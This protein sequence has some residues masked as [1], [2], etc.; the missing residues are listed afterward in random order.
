[1]RLS[2][3]VGVFLLLAGGTLGS[4]V[5][6]AG[7]E[8]SPVTAQV[9]G[10]VGGLE[11]QDV[12]QVLVGEIAFRRGQHE[13]AAQAYADV[14]TRL[15]DG[16]LFGRAVQ[17]AVAAQLNEL[18]LTVAQ[19]WVEK[20]PGSAAARQALA[21][22][23]AGVG[24]GAE[25]IPHLEKLLALDVESRPRN[26]LH[27]SRLLASLEPEAAL[28]AAKALIQPYAALPEAHFLLA[29]V[30][31]QAGQAELAVTSVREAV[32]LR[33]DWAP[34]AY[35][36]AQLAA[37][38]TDAIAVWTR[39]ISVSKDHEQAYVQRGRLYVGEKSYLAARADYEQALVLKPGSVETLYSLALLSLQLN[40]RAAAEKYFQRLDGRDFGARGMVD[41]QLGLLA[42]DRG[43]S[44]AAGRYFADV[45]KGDYYVRA[46]SQLA[47]MLSRQ[48]KMDEARR[49]L[50]D[51]EAATDEDRSR[52]AIVEAQ[53]L[54]EAKR[55]DAA[56][57]VI[58]KALVADP[59]DPDLL[60]D[61]AM[62]AERLKRVDLV[63][64]TLQRL[65]ELQPNNPHVLN[66][67]GYSWADRNIRLEEARQ[68]IVR[69]R[70]LAPQDPF[71]LDSL[72]WVSFRLGQPELALRQLEDAYRQRPDPEIAAHI[73][74][75]LWSL[76]RRDDARKIWLES[77]RQFPESEVLGAVIERFIP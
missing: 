60:Y 1:M 10:R 66:A 53:L 58:E 61:R 17:I 40:D 62:I 33:P 22:V 46:R 2:R 56:L 21:G 52:L 49:L 7:A 32:R 47:L 12:Y 20:D 42:Q 8:D 59:D 24:R 39:F 75:V 64:S 15:G 72:G 30:A 67:L 11:G 74:E 23:F 19:R 36:E 73:G 55:H 70:E 28:T 54:R 27:M 48:G 37:S 65:I 69:A 5:M 38:P 18:A 9:E 77:R 31:R 63:D 29:S 43:D 50:A 13:I 3:W 51:T 57:A 44:E 68:L 41:Y 71:I 25:M 4:G 35:F 26:L 45:G 6:A 76:D 16:A 14:A 34:A